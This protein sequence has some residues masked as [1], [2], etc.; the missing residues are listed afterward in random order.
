MSDLY[1][2]DE[3]RALSEVAWAVMPSKV[4]LLGAGDASQFQLAWR[5]ID[6]GLRASAHDVDPS[7]RV[8]MIESLVSLLLQV[9]LCISSR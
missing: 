9:C 6:A 5:S 8:A 7:T 1:K 2:A 3:L 4:D